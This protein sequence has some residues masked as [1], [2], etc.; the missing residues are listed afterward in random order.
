MQEA[1]N[2][3]QHRYGQNHQLSLRPPSCSAA[4]ILFQFQ[5]I[6]CWRWPQIQELSLNPRQTVTQRHSVEAS[7]NRTGTQKIQPRPRDSRASYQC[8]IPIEYNHNPLLLASGRYILDTVD[9]YH[10]N[11][12]PLNELRYISRILHRGTIMPRPH[13]PEYRSC[14]VSLAVSYPTPPASLNACYCMLQVARLTSCHCLYTNVV[15]RFSRP[16]GLGGDSA[17]STDET[18]TLRRECVEIKLKGAP[19]IYKAGG[20]FA[21]GSVV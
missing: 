20:G 16:W 15:R 13:S 6:R 11:T 4:G 9:L 7:K 2:H 12:L 8:S 1:S 10:T 14:T 19:G 5:V 3:P 18:S 17:P 21:Q